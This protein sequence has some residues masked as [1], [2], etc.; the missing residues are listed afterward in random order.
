M[1]KSVIEFVPPITFPN[2]VCDDCKRICYINKG[3]PGSV[4]DQ[5]VFQNSVI[6]KNP[7]VHFLDLEYLLGDL[8][9]TPSPTMVPAYKKYGGQLPFSA[10]RI[11]FDTM[12]WL[13]TIQH[14]SLGYHWRI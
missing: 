12:Y 10:G 7:G 1:L 13:I 6:S 4:H 11:S 8:A 3:W 9:Y 5:R 14:L 2:V